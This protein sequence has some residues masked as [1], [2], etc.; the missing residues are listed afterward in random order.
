MSHEIRT[1]INAVL[2]MANLLRRSGVTPAQAE[3]L[4]NIDAATRHLL[5][6]INDFLD[7]SKIEA[8]KLVLEDAVIAV[9]TLMGNVASIVAERAQARNLT[10]KI[11]IEPF[12]PYL[13]GDPT[14]IQ[15]AVL[16]YAA[17]A[18]KF[19]ESGTVTLRARPYEDT[20]GHLIGRFE[21]HDTG[22]GI[23]PETLKRL[24]GAFE[25]A[26]SSTTRRYGGT[27]LG[28]VIT[29]RLAEM[30]GGKVGVD[31]VPGK[32]STFWF[33]VRLSK[34]LPQH[35]LETS[36]EIMETDAEALIR[37][38]HRDRRILLVDD[39]PL[40][41]EVIQCLLEDSGLIVDAA[42]D[43]MQAIDKVRKSPYSL[44]LMDMQMPKLNGPDATRHIRRIPGY[45]TTPILAITANAFAEDKAHCLSAGM[46]DFL[47]KP[48]N[49]DQLFAS[50]FKWLDRYA[51]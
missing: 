36:A 29:K 32:G 3:R 17:N 19:T 24:F 48:F 9:D 22:I 49:P 4:D 44:I 41:L 39:E 16:N 21:V 12:P 28:L 2:G 1:P 50:L 18:I 7:L 25:Q 46:N 8:G 11:E 30:M 37:R 20:D 35:R 23:P 14:R 27:G 43:G 42:E 40:N 13:R 26:D 38:H 51:E 5:G 6:I 31:S 45:E 47:V 15:Q 34:V 10:L 33:T